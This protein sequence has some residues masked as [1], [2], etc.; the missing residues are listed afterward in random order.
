MDSSMDG[1]HKRPAVDAALSNPHLMNK[2]LLR[3]RQANSGVRS[4]RRVSNDP[5]GGA[6][7]G[8]VGRREP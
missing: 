7:G 8:L 2:S 3:N 6:G 1:D 4:S 5:H